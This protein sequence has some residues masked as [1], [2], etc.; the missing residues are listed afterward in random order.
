M[1]VAVCHY[2]GH[3][4]SVY[5]RVDVMPCV[6]RGERD[7]DL[8]LPSFWVILVFML[9]CHTKD[10]LLLSIRLVGCLQLWI[11]FQHFSCIQV[12]VFDAVHSVFLVGSSLLFWR[13]VSLCWCVFSRSDVCSYGRTLNLFFLCPWFPLRFQVISC[14][15]ALVL[16]SCMTFYLVYFKIHH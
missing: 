13:H 5:W 9:C 12:F 14:C 16:Y 3:T 8:Q 4:L 11:W 7:V 6:P 2:Y 1:F 10:L 15:F